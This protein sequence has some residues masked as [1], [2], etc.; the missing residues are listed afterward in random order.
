MRHMSG[1]SSESASRGSSITSGAGFGSSGEGISGVSSATRRTISGSEDISGR[2]G[3]SGSSKC[4][5][6]AGLKDGG[7]FSS[8]ESVNSSSGT[9]TSCSGV[10][11]S[12]GPS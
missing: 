6:S 8:M 7:I 11:S 3:V 12:I 2:E 10:S 9:F 1:T 5:T 4:S